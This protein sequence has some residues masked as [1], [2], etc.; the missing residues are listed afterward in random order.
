[1][2]FKAE[3]AKYDEFS[4]K[5][6]EAKASYM[7]KE[8]DF[9]KENSQIMT[10]NELLE[11]EVEQLKSE[12]EISSDDIL[13]L[14]ER[15]ENTREDFTLKERDLNL[16]NIE[17]VGKYKTDLQ[18]LN[19][20]NNNLSTQNQK[21]EI[22]KIKTDENTIL[23]QKLLDQLKYRLCKK[24]STNKTLQSKMD[25]LITQSQT[26]TGENQELKSALESF[27]EIERAIQGA[28]SLKCKTCMKLI[29]TPTFI[30]H[31]GKPLKPLI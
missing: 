28:S 20:E 23:V 2:R 13:E 10:Q 14:R 8:T 5:Y 16:N 24:H 31:I 15:I 30:T 19:K 21:L 25:S 29:S 26:L 3:I 4:Q 1:L 18:N 9:I 12:L 22:H 27:Q 6:D 7:E 11:N 17:K